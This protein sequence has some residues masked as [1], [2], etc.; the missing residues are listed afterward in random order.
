MLKILFV[1]D[2]PNILSGL[3]RM[4]YPMKNEWDMLFTDQAKTALEIIEK[5]NIDVIISDI[6][7]PGIDGS[8]LLSDVKKNYPSIIRITLSGYADDNIAMRNSRIVH[9]SLSKPTTAEKIHNTIKRI[10]NLRER[11]RDDELLEFIN[12]IEE[13][14]SLPEIYVKLEEEINLPNASIDRI[15]KI[16]Y[17]DP[18]ISVKILQLTNSAFFGL[19]NRIT[20]IVQALNYLGIKLI[21]NLVLSIKLFKS[22]D[23]K[24][25]HYKIYEEIWN[26]SSKVAFC[27]QTI[28]KLKNLSKIE[29][30]DSFLG[31]LLHDLGKIVLFEK[32]NKKEVS[33]LQEIDNIE[34]QFNSTSH[35]DIG[36]YL[37][38]VWGLPDSIIETVALHHFNDLTDG[39]EINVRKVVYVSNLIV[40]SNELTID[41]INQ[42]NIDEIIQEYSYITNER[43]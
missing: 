2:D 43:V 8:Q 10:I 14:P 24:H 13:L 23:T 30:D 33:S 35:A 29:V 26:H 16:I 34:N 18:L 40:H 28:A 22:I 6:R 25:P 42:E 21:Q 5:T 4:M 3:K 37:L 9:Q 15:A 38:G 32:L 27:A 11:L 36:A 20:N 31:G 1:D 39:D 17:S 41:D 19:P 7:M 12:G